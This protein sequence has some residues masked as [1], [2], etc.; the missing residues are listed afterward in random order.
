MT[1]SIG[2]DEEIARLK[3]ARA[4]GGFAS[5][6]ALA[7][8][9]GEKGLSGGVIRTMESRTNPRRLEPSERAVIARAC[10]VPEGFFTAPREQLGG[11]FREPATDADRLAV[12]ERMVAE[13]RE[14]IGIGADASAGATRAL[15]GAA[16]R[17]RPQRQQ[18]RQPP[19]AT[20][21]DAG[22]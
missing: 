3:A 5:P 16:E 15:S 9:I 14:T 20:R 18:R 1:N 4:L 7:D 17:S 6:Q 8:A 12:L 11:D 19:R 10:G 22:N 13:I 21:S 2:A